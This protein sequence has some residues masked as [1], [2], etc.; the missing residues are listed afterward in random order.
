M[1]KKVQ[2]AVCI[3]GANYM[4]E[5]INQLNKE[6]SGALALDDIEYIHRLRVASRRLR[7]GLELFQECFPGKKFQAHQE[8]IRQITKALGK[9]RDLDIQIECVEQQ[10]DK[11][12]DPRY[13]FGYGRLLLRLRQQRVKAQQK[14]AQTLN[15]LQDAQ[16]L[17]K[18]RSQLETMTAGSQNM[19]LFTPSLYKRSFNAINNRLEDFLSYQDDVHQPENTEK[20]HAMRI[21]GKHLRYTMEI[22]APIYEQALLPYIQYMK[23]LQD[24]LGEFH[25]ADVWIT[26]LP[27]FILK[28]QQRIIDYFGNSGPLKRLLPGFKYVIEDRQKAR[29]LHYQAFLS[30]WNDL[31]EENV[32]Q[33]MIELLQTPINVEA[34]LS[35]LTND[36]QIDRKSFV[37]EEI[38][39]DDKISDYEIE[40]NLDIAPSEIEDVSPAPDTSNQNNET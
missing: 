23:E 9:A 15:Q 11:L 30:T 21:S 10:Y 38:E 7:N 34:A 33:S 25:D 29:D 3:F 35:H 24:Q 22:F 26:W 40:L 16:I 31:Q 18:M 39:I 14:V 4:L 36:A 8:N 5:Q 12:P 1:A 2:K 37:E 13:K 19:Y 27:Q 20:L 17:D 32:W 6:I 28:E